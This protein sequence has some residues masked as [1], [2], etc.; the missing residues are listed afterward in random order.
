VKGEDAPEAALEAIA[1]IGMSCRFPGAPDLGRFWE[2]LRDG[3]ECISPVSDEDLAVSRV[4]PAISSHPR[5]VRAAAVL[6]GVDQFDHG[7]FGFTPREAEVVDPAHRLFLEC[8]WEALEAAGCDPD[9]FKGRI[10]IY[11]GA[12]ASYY[13]IY[14]ITGD[15][16]LGRAVNPVQLLTSSDKDYLPTLAAYK[17]NLTGPSVGVQTA[18]SSGLVAVNLASQSLMTYQ[19][20]MAVVGD[21]AV[22]VPQRAGYVYIP[23][24]IQSPDGSC[25]AFDAAAAGTIFGSG[26]G[27]VVLRRL[28]DALAAGDPILAVIRGSA[29]NND[30][31]AKSG[32]TAPSA[33]AQAEVIAL[34]LAMADIGPET[35]GYVEAHGT[36]TPLGDSIE[37]AALEQVFRGRVPERSC[38]LGSVKTNIGHADT[39]A[40]MAALIKTVLALQQRQIPASLHFERPNPQIDFARS[41]FYVNA[42]LA[43]WPAGRGP[44]RAGVNSF[45]IGGTNAH[46]IVEEAP[47]AAPSGPARA[48]QVL[49]LSARSAP[50]LEAMGERLSAHLRQH[51]EAA[52]ADV[53]YTLQVGRKRFA[54]RRIVLCQDA[55][56]AVL[57]LAGEQRELVAN[58]VGKPGDAAVV[59][60]F[61]GQ[62]SLY[63]G[64][65]RG[66]HDSE[67]AFHEALD[68]CAQLLLPEI[69]N[70]LR[71]LLYPEPGRQAWAAERLAESANAQP[72]L[73]AVE[74]ALAKMW[75]SWGVR[76][77]ATIG[78]GSGEQAGAL[79]ADSD[80]AEAQAIAGRD[81]GIAGGLE[82]RVAQEKCVGGGQSAGGTGGALQKF[83]AREI[84]FHLGLLKKIEKPK[85]TSSAK[86]QALRAQGESEQ[87]S[88]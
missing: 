42:R 5:Y 24:G 15:R 47:A 41:P 35:I 54:H 2:V 46:V 67:P 19:C 63:V 13:L 29:V 28:S 31:A 80:D 61:P 48:W 16:E 37:V 32:F 81:A 25:R 4:D 69:G 88:V 22:R 23:G 1:V 64:M 38:A 62:G 71:A 6:Q 9:R 34:A 78:H 84:T 73:F 36:A 10:G 33:R 72:A 74:Y 27:V 14:N 12:A 11:A 66:L 30:G 65:G 52:A 79:H 7:F 17:L 18:C 3:V 21:A 83:A 20:D 43:P 85:K 70:D 40:G 44:R 8:A 50:A 53:A 87:Q 82:A 75:L 76:P 26:V 57:A 77:A 55:A 68:S 45:G 86:K 56:Q 39:A 51:P 58:A 49:P 59:F 60:V